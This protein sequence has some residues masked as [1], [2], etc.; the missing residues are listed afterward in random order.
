MDWFVLP[1]A[2]K[3]KDWWLL[4]PPLWSSLK[5][6]I[7]LPDAAAYNCQTHIYV[8][9]T[10]CLRYKIPSQKMYT[11][12][13]ELK[14]CYNAAVAWKASAFSPTGSNVVLV[15]SGVVPKDIRTV[16]AGIQI[17]N[18][19]IIGRVARP[20]EPQPSQFKEGALWAL[21]LN[22]GFL[23]FLLVSSRTLAWHKHHP[24]R[25][26]STD[27]GW[28]FWLV[29]LWRSESQPSPLPPLSLAFQ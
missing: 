22:I 28:C 7:N 10:M 9:Y 24:S 17:S 19:L 3:V 5:K 20:V 14:C 2:S 21:C 16:E 29:L 6:P 25:F 15:F 1:L 27:K 26:S 23:L 11:F 12:L 13:H 8:V 18:T 4:L